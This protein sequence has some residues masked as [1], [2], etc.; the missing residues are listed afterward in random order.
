MKQLKYKN[1][2]E[3]DKRRIC[4]WK[5][6]GEYEIY[7]LPSY[8]VMKAR[9]TGFMNPSSEKNYLAFLDKDVLVG[10]VN[11][12]E[13]DKEVF[14]GIG[15]DPAL[16]GRHYGRRILEEAYHISKRLYPQNRCIWKCGPG[17]R[18]L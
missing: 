17:T 5:Y 9:Q 3:D 13:K 15:V 11:I 18:G 12:F 8:D 2:S 14:I 4:A 1:L 6:T 16:C 7:N 10:F